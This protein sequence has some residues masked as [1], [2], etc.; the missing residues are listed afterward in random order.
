MLKSTCTTQL[1]L[2]PQLDTR[3]AALRPKTQRA[4]A[5][6]QQENTLPSQ[7]RQQ[8]HQHDEQPQQQPREQQAEQA[9]NSVQGLNTVSPSPAAAK[10]DT[11]GLESSRNSENLENL[12]NK[13]GAQFGEF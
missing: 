13:C 6:R 7:Q 3:K 8:Q 12:E 4:F 2:L 1:T 11:D 9:K 10:V 5:Q